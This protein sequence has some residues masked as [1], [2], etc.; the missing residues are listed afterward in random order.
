MQTITTFAGFPTATSMPPA[1]SPTLILLVKDGF[2][3]GICLFLFQD[4]IES[5][6]SGGV[7]HSVELGGGN[8]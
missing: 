8:I 5:H 1:I 6:P 4:V 7:E 2:G 3:V